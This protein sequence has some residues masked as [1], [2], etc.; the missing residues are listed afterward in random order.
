MTSKQAQKQRKFEAQF[1]STRSWAENLLLTPAYSDHIVPFSDW[2]DRDWKA[3]FL[4]HFQD[5]M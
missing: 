4:Q 3:L 5:G 2:L 1:L